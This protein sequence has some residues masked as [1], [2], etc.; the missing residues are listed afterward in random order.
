MGKATVRAGLARRALL[1]HGKTLLDLEW[2]LDAIAATNELR[3]ARIPVAL[4]TL[5]Y[6][7]RGEAQAVTLQVPGA[8]RRK[9]HAACGELLGRKG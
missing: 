7:E 2:R 6:V 8:A 1:R 5:H 3:G 9:L 4:L